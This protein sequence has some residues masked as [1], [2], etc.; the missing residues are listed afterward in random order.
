VKAILL[1]LLLAATSVGGAQ[2][3]R[4]QGFQLSGLPALNYNSDEGFGYGLVAGLYDHGM[5]DRSPYV[6]SFEPLIFFTTEGRREVSA[7]FD[8]P[9][10]L[11]GAARLTVFAGFLRD[12]C[13]PY[14]GR[15]NGTTY[16]AASAAP[17]AGPNFYTYRRERWS[18]VIDLQWRV[19]RGLRL[20]TGVA[21]HHNAGTARDPNTLFALEGLGGSSVSLGPKLGLVLDT[22][23]R[24]RDPTDGVWVD[25]L[26]WQGLAILG[27]D[28]RFTRVTATVRNYS[29]ISS[30]FTFATRILVEH[31]AGDM[32]VT[33]LPDIGSSFRDFS[34]V[35]GAKTVRGVLRDRFLGRTRLL[36]NYELRWRGVP[37]RALGQPWRAGAVAFSDGGRVWAAGDGFSISDI[38][39]LHYG[40]GAGLRLVWGESFI[41]AFDLASGREAGVQTYLGL[42]QLY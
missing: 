19:A 2:E 18:G 17:S 27:A 25:I 1:G 4:A 10:I 31:V 28:N 6:W 37:F 39:D 26:V 14:Y 40:S 13:Q 7:V 34:G 12:C 29:R 23:D 41:V 42:G 30:A 16:N 38:G 21:A 11:D 20:L 24:E 5:G 9:Y 22:R 33:M 8:A 35:G 3:P 15:G 32:P 36:T